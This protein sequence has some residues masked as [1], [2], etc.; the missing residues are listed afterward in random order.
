MFKGGV[1]IRDDSLMNFSRDMYID[2]FRPFDQKILDE[3]GGGSIHFCGKGDHYI[4]A[5]TEMNGVTGINMAQPEYN[6]FETIFRHTIDKG[7]MLLSLDIDVA[8]SV[9]RPLHGLV[10]CE[11][12]KG[13]F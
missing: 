2:I 6:E 12:E 9:D 13:A 11:L 3:F 5:V 10:Q 8:R 4:D 1:M 7:I